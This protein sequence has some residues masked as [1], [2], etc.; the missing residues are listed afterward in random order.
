MDDAA[1]WLKRSYGLCQEV[2]LK[3]TYTPEEFDH[4]EVLTS[5]YGRTIDLIVNKAFRTIDYFELESGGTIIDVINR[6]HKRGIIHSVDEIREMKELRNEISHE[7][8]NRQLQSI[9]KSVLSFTP[10]IFDIY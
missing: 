8:A 1:K 9:F 5:R 2:G 6:A 7:Y 3:E 4:F 10:R